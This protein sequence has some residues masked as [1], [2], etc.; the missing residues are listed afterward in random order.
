MGPDTT[1]ASIVSWIFDDGHG[2][3][4]STSMAPYHA[5]GEAF[6]S[7]EI[8]YDTRDNIDSQYKPPIEASAVRVF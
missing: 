8:G 6:P 2:A 1:A 4:L 7:I 5:I 3:D